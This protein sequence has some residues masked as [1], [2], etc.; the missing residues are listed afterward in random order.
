MKKAIAT[1]AEALG[2]TPTVC[3]KY[4]IHAGLFDAYLHGQLP[5]M[6]ARLKLTR[7]RSLTRDEQIL[8]P[9]LAGA[10]LIRPLF[11]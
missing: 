1:V 3:R 10:H 8:A 2:N 9:F 6:F 11:S 5:T 4:Y 7:Q